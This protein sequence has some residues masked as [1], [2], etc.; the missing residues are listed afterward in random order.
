MRLRLLV[1]GCCALMAWP[2]WGQTG[3]GGIEF[4]LGASHRHLE[5]HDADGNRLLREAGA[6]PSAQAE[7]WRSL[8]PGTVYAGLAATRQALD[9]DGRSQLG[10]PIR[11]RSDYRGERLWL[12]YRLALDTAWA[13]GLRWER[14]TLRRSIRAVGTINGLDERY[15]SDWLGLGV[16]YR[17]AHPRLAW[18]E[19][20]WRQTVDSRVTVASTGVIDPVSLPLDRRVGLRISARIPLWQGAAGPSLAIEPAG[21]WFRTRAS[22]ERIWTHDGVPRGRL[23]Q[24]RQTDW[25]LGAGLVLSW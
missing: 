21:S 9:Y 10:R 20:E 15:R 8:G 2:A 7:G 12:G 16:R 13:V 24:P 25:Q 1:P 23:R 18:I 5:E 3:E 6:A 22:D 19:A 11:T 14:E 17:P 4:A